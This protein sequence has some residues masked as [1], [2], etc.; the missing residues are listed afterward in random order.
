MS[1][2]VSVSAD[3]ASRR[4]L[5]KPHPDFTDVPSIRRPTASPMTGTLFILAR[6]AQGGA[7]LVMVEAAAVAAEGRITHGDVGIWNDEQIAPLERIA[8]LPE[9]QRRRARRSSSRMPA[10]RPACSGPGTATPRSIEADRA[11]GDLPWRTV[12]PSAIA[13]EEGWLMPRALEA[14][15]LAGVAR[16]DGG[17]PRL[18]AVEAGFEFVEVHCAH[19]YLLARIP[20]AACRTAAATP[21]AATAPGRMRYPLEVI[22]TVRAAWPAGAARWRCGFLRSTASRAA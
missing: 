22:E 8:R 17:A 4:D 6:F 12:A 13:M 20:L 9:G 21:M 10:A 15:E 2:A 7:G 3:H 18:R 19:G 14:A 5:P 16:A 1:Q 11:R